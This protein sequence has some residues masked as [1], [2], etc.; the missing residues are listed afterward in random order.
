MEVFGDKLEEFGFNFFSGV[1]CSFLKPMI[2]YA[3]NKNQFVMAANEGDAVA[4]AA[5]AYL[6]GQKVFF[7]AK[8][9][10]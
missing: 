7:Y 9:Q 5:G 2:N 8:T 4:I 1:P 6:G 3:I 10:V